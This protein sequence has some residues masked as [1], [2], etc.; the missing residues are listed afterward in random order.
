MAWSRGNCPGTKR[1]MLPASELLHRLQFH[2]LWGS[3]LGNEV[4]HIASILLL[5]LLFPFLCPFCLY[6]CQQLCLQVVRVVPS[7]RRLVDLVL[8][9]SASWARGPEPNSRTQGRTRG[10]PRNPNRSRRSRLRRPRWRLRP[11][12]LCWHAWPH[13]PANPRWR[14]G[15]RRSSDSAPGRWLGDVPGDARGT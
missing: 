7:S 9:F 12:R 14:S 1:S 10:P 4:L 6:L 15:G 5:E 8:Q 13:R 2:R 11:C 3:L